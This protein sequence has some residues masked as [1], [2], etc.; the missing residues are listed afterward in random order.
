M[1]ARYRLLS[2]RGHLVLISSATSKRTL[3]AL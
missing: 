1:N 3:A 2:L